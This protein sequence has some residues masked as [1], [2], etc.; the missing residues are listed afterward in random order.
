MYALYEYGS[1][2]ISIGGYYSGNSTLAY[3]ISAHLPILASDIA[4]IRD[5]ADLLIHPNHTDQLAEKL[6]LLSRLET[7]TEKYTHSPHALIDVY[8]RVIAESACK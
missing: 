1:G 7:G 4:P 5:Y 2:W 3:A 8:A 6:L